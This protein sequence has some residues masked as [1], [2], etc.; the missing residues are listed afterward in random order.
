VLVRSSVGV[1][2]LCE[3][4]CGARRAGVVGGDDGVKSS[5]VKA[6][7]VELGVVDGDHGVKSSQV[8]ARHVE[9]G[10]VD[11]DHG[12]VARGGVHRF[13]VVAVQDLVLDLGVAR[14]PL[15]WLV[16]C[17]VVPAVRQCGTHTHAYSVQGRALTLDLTHNATVQQRHQD[18]C[19]A[20]S[21]EHQTNAVL[22]GAAPSVC[23]HECSGRGVHCIQWEGRACTV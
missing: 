11:G 22:G 16:D 8:K 3:P 2:A 23:G 13:E 12:A 4:G 18:R 19:R 21:T 5:Q 1:C 6:R 9:L 20:V 15:D 7:H 17:R 14:V 10:V